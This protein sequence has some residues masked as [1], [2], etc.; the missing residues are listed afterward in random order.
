MIFYFYMAIKLIFKYSDRHINIMLCGDVVA[1]LVVLV[2]TCGDVA[3]IC[4]PLLDYLE[5]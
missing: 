4:P 5:I 1:T 3:T 2:A